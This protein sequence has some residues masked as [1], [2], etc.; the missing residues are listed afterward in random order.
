M[1]YISLRIIAFRHQ[2]ML[3]MLLFIWII[4]AGSKVVGQER[5]NLVPLGRVFDVNSKTATDSLGYM[6]ISDQDGIYKFD[7]YDFKRLAFKKIFGPKFKSKSVN[8]FE[9]DRQNNFWIGTENS[10]LVSINPQGGVTDYSKQISGV[11]LRSLASAKNQVYFGSATGEIW[12]MDLSLKRIKKLF[13]LPGSKDRAVL[14]MVMSEKNEL[15]ISTTDNEVFIYSLPHKRLTK[16][17][18]PIK[19]NTP[20]MFFMVTDH[21]SRLWVSTEYQ[22][23]FC[24][25]PMTGSIQRYGERGDDGNAYMMYRSIYCDRE[26]IIWLGTDGY[27]LKKLDPNTG[28]IT[29]YR[30][31][32]GN[33]YSLSNNTVRYINGDD[34]GNIWVIV[35][36]GIVQVLSHDRYPIRNYSGLPS[37]TPYRILSMLKASDNSIW[38][39][40]DGKGL[41]RIAANGSRQHFDLSNGFK[42]RFIQALVEDKKGN[43]WIG[44]YQNGLFRYIKDNQVFQDVSVSGDPNSPQALDFRNLYVDSKGRV[45][46]GSTL[47][48]HVFDPNGHLLAT[49]N[50]NIDAAKGYI[51]D[52]VFEDRDGQIWVS[53]SQ[54]LL[55]QFFENKSDLA[56]SNFSNVPYHLW[57]NRAS[58]YYNISQIVQDNKGTLWFRCDGGFLIQLDPKRKSYHSFEN[59]EELRY[60]DITSILKDRDGM[61]WLGSRNGLHQFDPEKQKIYTYTMH[62]GLQD[63]LFIRKSAFQS[64]DEE[65]FFGGNNGVSSFY[66]KSL[67]H[68]PMSAN[69]VVNDILVLNK[70]FD[71]VLPQYQYERVENLKELH[72]KAQQ[73]SFSIEFAAIGDLLNTN[74]RY[75]YRLKGFEES[76]SEPSM[77]RVA[78]YTNLPSGSYTFEV[79]AAHPGSELFDIGPLSLKVDIAPYWWQST[80]AKLI[81]LV[82]G[83]ALLYVIWRWLLLRARLQREEIERGHEKKLY[84][85]KMNFFAKI[86]HEIQTPLSLIIG[87]LE[88][89]FAKQDKQ[90]ELVLPQ[91]QLHMIKNNAE[92]LSRIVSELTHVRDKEIGKLTLKERENDLISH[93]K[94][95]VLSFKELAAHKGIE[96]ITELPEESCIIKYDYLKLEH[97]FYNLLGNAVKFTPFGG[98]IK[99]GVIVSKVEQM[100]HV[101]VE[102]SGPGMDAE[103][104]SKIFQMFYQGNV[105]KEQGGLGIGLALSREIMQLHGGTLTVKSQLG[106]GAR[107]EVAMPLRWAETNGEMVAAASLM[108]TK[109]ALN[110]ENK[111]AEHRVLIVE[112]NLDMQ[113]FLSEL[114]ASNF[115]LSVVDNGSQAIDFLKN[116]TVDLILSDVM[117]PEMDGLQ[118]AEQIHTDM[119]QKHIPMILLTA[120]PSDVVRKKSLES[121]VVSYL[122]K[123]FHPEE[124]LLLMQNILAKQ[125]FAVSQ[126]RNKMTSMPVVEEGKLPKS[127]VFLI[128]LTELLKTKISDPDFLLEDLEGLMHMSYSVIFKKCQEFTGF[129]PSEYFRRIKIKKAAILLSQ[130]NYAVS[131]A[132]FEVGFTDSKYFS[133][134]FKET[135]GMTPSVFRTKVRPENLEDFLQKF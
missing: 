85:V 35:K 126:F 71:E 49:F 46:A 8:L 112:D 44:S 100:L 40:T 121:G 2:M 74:Y 16:L 102:D 76:F 26:G 134:L 130:Y 75:K 122:S 66:P 48:L 96:L 69:L 47:G 120:Y 4:G 11:V 13:L 129:T 63:N 59:H 104:V 39:G 67:S 89:L 65:L 119:Q 62:D 9:K 123:P 108:K 3:C 28:K 133:K 81:Y 27:G 72:L 32:L 114:L 109:D 10:E 17:Q 107:F 45:W 37:Q 57:D 80:V 94:S 116:N 83:L 25:D 24:Y 82:V 30:Q 86:S 58:R 22:G 125:Q 31:Q 1:I 43:I 5:V 132:A 131:E 91:K 117:M 61:L 90:D 68:K 103:T 78:T 51:S 6:W 36:G 60:I 50:K 23:L 73:S 64:R 14:D 127:D 33:N 70:P 124:L 54:G 21:R 111:N 19:S 93:L 110:S 18:L 101:T 29:T 55:S 77:G 106:K 99:L 15:Y 42:G 128:K 7:G 79:I 135:F 53:Y 56:R 118:L 87:P 34:N 95:I 98:E 52:A 84:Q 20:D 41:S 92:R 12:F 105:G 97:V 88:T 113:L 115:Q 38:I